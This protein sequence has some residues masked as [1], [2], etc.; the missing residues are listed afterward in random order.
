MSDIARGIYPMLYT[1]FDAAG[2]VDHDQV[3]RGVDAAIA[4]GV[5]GIAW[6]G[7]ASEANKLSPDEKRA[8]A[9][10]VLARVARRVPV[11]ITLTES[12]AER[13]IAAA[14][15]AFQ[16]GADWVV[17][18][19]PH[20][21]R[22]GEDAL[23]GHYA[24][25]AE[26]V[27]GPVGIQNAPE[28]I[29]VS[30]SHAGI[31]RLLDATENIRVLKA[32]GS[33]LYIAELMEV[34]GGRAAVMNGRNGL[35]LIDDLRLGCIGCIPGAE[36]ADVQAAIFDAFMAGDRDGA[37]GTYRT[38]LPLLR[39]LMTTIDGILCYGKRLAAE[40]FSLGEVHDRLPGMLPRPAGLEIVS[41][42]A[43]ALPART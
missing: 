27:A 17:L 16:H 8:L 25:I 2:R 11:S 33:A 39:Q 24:R 18:Q 40:R 43:R 42:W 9:E 20:V 5:H 19:P 26:A 7:L 23:V 14:A 28:F 1:F 41:F 35:D 30:L 3:R 22:L 13:Q 29:A 31:S 4:C 6:G 34:V 21:G 38:L 10:T 37:I 15:H 36:A 32:E 12:T